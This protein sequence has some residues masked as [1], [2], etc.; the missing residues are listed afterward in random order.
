MTTTRAD[1]VNK[2]NEKIGLTKRKSEEFVQSFF[3]QL[4]DA[5]EKRQDVKL[6]GFGRF[7]IFKKQERMGRNPKTGESSI[8]KARNTVCFKASQK[9]K[10]R[11][12]IKFFEVPNQLIKSS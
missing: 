11:I 3:L 6:V 4:I 8:I 5:L 2:L 1:L 7:K 9:L 10:S 12:G